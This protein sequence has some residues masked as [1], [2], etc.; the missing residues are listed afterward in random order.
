MVRDI[1]DIRSSR[2]GDIL[3]HRGEVKMTKD[4]LKKIVAIYLI[5]GV[6]FMMLVFMGRFWT[7]YLVKPEKNTVLLLLFLVFPTA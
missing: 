1:D 4:K 6:L 3:Q 5:A 7:D 2:R